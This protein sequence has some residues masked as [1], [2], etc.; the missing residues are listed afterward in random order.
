MRDNSGLK[1]LNRLKRH[2]PALG[3]FLVLA[4]TGTVGMVVHYLDHAFVEQTNRT[5]APETP[6]LDCV[7]NQTH[8]LFAIL[9]VV[10]FGCLLRLY[11]HLQDQIKRQTAS[12]ADLRRARNL[13]TVVIESTPVAIV[14]TNWEGQVQLW[15]PQ[16]EAMF[17]WSAD[18]IEGRMLSLLLPEEVTDLQQLLAS[19]RTGKTIHQQEVLCQRR[20]G[21]LFAAEVSTAPVYDNWGQGLGI[22]STFTDIS[23]RKQA[24]QQLL[25]S[26]RQDQLTGLPNRAV[27]QERL[28]QAF[29]RYRRHSQ[30]LFAVVFVDLDRFKL[31]NDT[32]GHA[33][34]DQFLQ[35]TAQ[36]ISQSIRTEDIVSRLGGDEFVIVLELVYDETHALSCAHRIQ[37]AIAQPLELADTVLNPNASVGLALAHPDY[38]TCDEMLRDADQAMYAAKA[39]GR[40]CCRVFSQ[41]AKQT[42]A[43]D[44]LEIWMLE[45]QASGPLG[46]M[47]H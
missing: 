26:A 25:I 16:A 20:D 14:F 39:S 3:I 30:Q 7:H 28:E 22:V 12:A 6:S 1:Q 42:E 43:S 36:R 37:A 34:G 23:D 44:A 40:G 46:S 33:I 27:L 4:V 18:F 8:W 10:N 45:R 38:T 32:Y 24:E 41:P 35:A 29:V 9:Y 15:N 21:S 31:I 47:G 19:T 11:G 5:T 17:G 2:L 13:L